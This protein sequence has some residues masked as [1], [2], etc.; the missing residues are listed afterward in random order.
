MQ[1]QIY[2][3]HEKIRVNFKIGSTQNFK[4]RIAG[5]ITGCDYFD[6][7]THQI[8]LFNIIDS[9]YTCYQLDWII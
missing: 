7:D 2:I 1:S 8:V 4:S 5:Y 9:K 6:S 3:L